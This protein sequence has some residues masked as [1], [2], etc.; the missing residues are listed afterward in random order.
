MASIATTAL[1]TATT[2]KVFAGNPAAV[3]LPDCWLD[4]STLQSIAIEN[5]L[6]E[7]AFAVPETNGRYRLRWF[8]PGG[9]IDLCGHATLATAYV[10][11]HFVAPEEQVFRFQTMSGELVVSRDGERLSMDFPAY[12]MK[13]IPVTDAM[14]A[15]IGA[16][17]AAAYMGR[18]L[19]CVLP[20]ED[21]VRQA[22]PDMEEMKSLDGL[23]LHITAQ[24]T[25]YDCVSRSFAPKLNVAED[26]VC[27]SGHCHI[28]P[29]WGKALGKDHIKAYQAS[30]RGGELYCKLDGS[31]VTLAGYACLYSVAELHV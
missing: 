15:V 13:E 9:E 6:S 8:T 21:D 26:P 5:N 31:R 1:N 27:G 19:V 10:L 14:A 25:D 7:T 29:I 28:V 16:R 22:M 18:D 24:G 20:A 11:A 4:D 2:D 3:C 23:L 17:P 30:K 12:E